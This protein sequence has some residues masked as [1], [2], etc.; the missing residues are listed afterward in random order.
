MRWSIALALLL[1]FLA[2]FVAT[3]K[4]DFVELAEIGRSGTL[5]SAF[6]VNLGWHYLFQTK[7]SETILALVIFAGEA[8]KEL[9][10]GRGGLIECRG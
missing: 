6:S 7:D 8:A 1:A 5:A 3:G 4:F 10:V 9:A 2:I